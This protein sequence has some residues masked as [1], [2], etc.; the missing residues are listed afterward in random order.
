MR[1]C[2]L[3]FVTLSLCGHVCVAHV[4]ARGEG[5]L[6][7]FACACAPVRECVFLSVCQTHLCLM[8]RQSVHIVCALVFVR[9]CALCV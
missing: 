2:V 6:F 9:L 1:V 3:L 7:I 5:G 4:C 8:Y